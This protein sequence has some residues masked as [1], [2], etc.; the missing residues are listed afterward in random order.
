MGMA[1]GSPVINWDSSLPIPTQ[2]SLPVSVCVW[3]SL[4]VPS[5]KTLH[6]QDLTHAGW[7]GKGTESWPLE[8]GLERT[9]HPCCA[10]H[11]L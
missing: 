3:S 8:R 11:S 6:I 4:S 2:P 10:T 1:N 9:G 5:S 7:V